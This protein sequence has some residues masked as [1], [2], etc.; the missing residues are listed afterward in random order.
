MHVHRASLDF[1]ATLSTNYYVLP[2]GQLRGGEKENSAGRKVLPAFSSK[3]QGPLPD[4]KLAYMAGLPGVTSGPVTQRGDGYRQ[5]VNMLHR[6]DDRQNSAGW[7]S[8]G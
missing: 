4:R 7:L 5:E 2:Y 1:H 3:L 6:L 8:W